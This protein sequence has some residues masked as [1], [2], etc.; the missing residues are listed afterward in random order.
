MERKTTLSPFSPLF[1]LLCKEEVGA[2]SHFYSIVL[3]D[4]TETHWNGHI[5]DV[6]FQNGLSEWLS[7]KN[8]HE[9]TER[10]YGNERQESV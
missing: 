3:F 9:G 5:S 6:V 2:S 8:K 10:Q 7:L 4:C 1:F